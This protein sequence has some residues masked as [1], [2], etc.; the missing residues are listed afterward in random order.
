[1]ILEPKN[2][3]FYYL[4]DCTLQKC[5]MLTTMG[6]LEE[7]FGNARLHAVRLIAALLYTR[8]PRIHHEL[9]RL[10]V[11]NLLLVMSLPKSSNKEYSLS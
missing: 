5:V 7:P 1:M 2:A 4:F 6:V 8:A 10:N 11:I 3:C 9:C